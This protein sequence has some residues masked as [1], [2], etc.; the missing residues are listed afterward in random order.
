MRK[1]KVANCARFVR[2]WRAAHGGSVRRHYAELVQ[3]YE[4]APRR[5]HTL[6]HVEDMLSMLDRLPPRSVDDRAALELAIWYHDVVYVPRRS[7][8]ERRSAQLFVRHAATARIPR[9]TLRRVVALILMTARHE[10]QPHDTDAAVLS[11]LDC[12][13]LGAPWPVFMRY[14]AGIRHESRRGMTLSL[15]AYRAGRHA[16]LFS[17]FRRR[18]LFHTEYFARVYHDQARSNLARLSHEL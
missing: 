15:G 1:Y 3:H 14:E 16:F 6:A 8:N 7:D 2:A 10:P 5:Y 18:V 11:D 17:L 9:R 13:V 4:R 12:A